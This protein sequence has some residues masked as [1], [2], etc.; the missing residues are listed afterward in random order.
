MPDDRLAP[1]QSAAAV[2]TVRPAH[3]GWN[4]QTGASNRFQKE[5][6]A[7]AP[8][9]AVLARA[10][11]AVLAQALRGAGVEVHEFEDRQHPACPD[12]VFPNNWFSTHHDGSVVLYP[13]LAPIRRL[14][15]RLDLVH[16][17]AERAGRRVSRLV[18]LTHHEAHGRFLE[19][20][21]SVVFDHSA[22]RAYACR[23]PRTH[24]EPLHELCDELG[25]E[26]YVFHAHDSHGVPVYHTNVL[27][28]VGTK[29]A[30]FAADT[31]EQGA[32]ERLLESLA[33]GGRHV[34]CI[35]ARQLAGFAGNVLEIEAR[36]GTRVL[37]MSR[38]AADACGAAALQR[39]GYCVDRVVTADIPTIETLGG[40]SVR[41]MLAEVFLPRRQ[42]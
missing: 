14:E 21:G 30:L 26:P 1:A 29:F 4:P 10:E 24:L 8:R 9:A 36:D 38:R 32:R 7:L 34:E 28:S 25:Y 11:A 40:G 37:A 19:G 17:L 31:V 33:A 20:T 22:R 15:R 5:D 12:A 41:C 42:A 13:L 27:L 18:D 6:P 39:L 16:E 2:L 23:S 35:D 3:F